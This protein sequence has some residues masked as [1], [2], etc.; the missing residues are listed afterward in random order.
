VAAGTCAG[1]RRRVSG[2]GGMETTTAPD[3]MAHL[4][5]R[6]LATAASARRSNTGLATMASDRVPTVA[7][8][9]QWGRA[10]DRASAQGERR[11]QTGRARGARGVAS[12]S[13]PTAAGALLAWHTRGGRG[14]N[15]APG[16]LCHLTC[17]PGTGR[18]ATDPRAPH[19][20]GFRTF[21]KTQKS[22]SKQ[23]K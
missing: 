5:R 16:G 11:L 3:G 8:G 7:H 1:R 4:A 9:Q 6:R 12:D 22:L 14:R 2:G 21:R 10:S 19:V 23:E 15:S 13:V 20:S 18:R 17:G